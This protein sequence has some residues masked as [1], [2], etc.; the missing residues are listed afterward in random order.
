MS[1]LRMGL[2]LFLSMF[3]APLLYALSIIFIVLVLLSKVVRFLSTFCCIQFFHLSTVHS[4]FESHA[5]YLHIFG[6][7]HLHRVV[8]VCYPEQHKTSEKLVYTWRGAWFV[9][10]FWKGIRLNFSSWREYTRAGRI[11]EYKCMQG[12][13]SCFQSIWYNWS[14]P[15]QLSWVFLWEQVYH[16]QKNSLLMF[17][18]IH[19]G[20]S[21]HYLNSPCSIPT[22]FLSVSNQF[23][24]PVLNS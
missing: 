19:V 24:N 18:V 17:R 16:V 20:E 14:S 23:I 5:F 8:G 3:Y 6:D 15:V 7:N 22:P 13:V 4:S 9:M 21:S 2:V 10:W 1:K 12:Y 11:M